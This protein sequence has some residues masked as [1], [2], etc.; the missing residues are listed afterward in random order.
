MPVSKSEVKKC[1][2]GW[3]EI[4]W[5][6]K[7]NEINVTEEEEKCLRLLHVDSDHMVGECKGVVQQQQQQ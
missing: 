4:G 7:K 5:N 2:G 1:N 3:K 6:W